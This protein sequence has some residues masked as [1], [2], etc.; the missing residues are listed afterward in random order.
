VAREHAPT[1]AIT[2]TQIA[3]LIGN[4]TRTFQVP[5]SCS[6]RRTDQTRPSPKGTLAGPGRRIDTLLTSRPAL[7]PRFVQQPAQTPADLSVAPLE[8]LWARRRILGEQRGD[9]GEGE[10]ALVPQ[11]QQHLP[12][13]RKPRL[14]EH[15]HAPRQRRPAMLRRRVGLHRYGRGL[16]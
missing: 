14:E 13:L 4:P 3:L 15:L 11:H 5:I 10:P 9:L 8:R 16:P 12:L 1:P 2:H 6:F 7:G